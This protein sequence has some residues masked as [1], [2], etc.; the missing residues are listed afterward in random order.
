MVQVQGILLI[1]AA[2]VAS[3]FPLVLDSIHNKLQVNNLLAALIY[4]L[5]SAS[6]GVITLYKEKSIIEYA[7]YMDIHE[8]SARLFQFQVLFALLLMP[9]FYVLQ[10]KSC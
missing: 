6:Q 5:A 9:L 2:M 3:I 4:I 10:G 7:L 1:C 8:M